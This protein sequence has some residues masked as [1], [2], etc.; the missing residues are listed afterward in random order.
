MTTGNYQNFKNFKSVTMS[1]VQIEQTMPARLTYNSGSA[2]NND[3][4][5]SQGEIKVEQRRKH[6]SFAVMSKRQVGSHEFP[7]NQFPESG[8]NN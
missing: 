6:Q 5:V 3:A 4:N 8:E 2:M 7:P 1:E